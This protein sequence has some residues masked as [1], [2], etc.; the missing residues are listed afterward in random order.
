MWDKTCARS[1]AFVA[2]LTSHKN[3]LVDCRKHNS[4]DSI[5]WVIGDNSDNVHIIFWYP[6]C[7]QQRA[8]HSRNL[9][10]STMW[11][12]TEKRMFPRPAINPS[13]RG[14]FQAACSFRSLSAMISVSGL[15]SSTPPTSDFLLGFILRCRAGAGESI[16]PPPRPPVPTRREKSD[17]RKA[18]LIKK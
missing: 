2:D 5:P 9:L 7:A 1:M 11:R 13:S 8:V 14:F 17:F 3:K 6:K 12:C 18:G 4:P 16:S 10:L 15:D